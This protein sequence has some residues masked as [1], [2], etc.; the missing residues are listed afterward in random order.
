VKLR[1]NKPALAD[2]KAILATSLE[3]W[4]HAAMVRYERL[5]VAAIEELATSRSRL[6][7]A[8][9]LGRGVRRF[10]VRQVRERHGVAAPVHVIYFR[11]T[12]S[13][14]SILR[15]LHERMDAAAQLA[16]RRR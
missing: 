1:I 6:P 4:G 3:R 13:S 10:H 2:L 9:Q 8:R 5:L 16:P 15:I 7:S 12:A 11:V 14:V